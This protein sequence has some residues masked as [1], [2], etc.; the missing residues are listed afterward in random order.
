M[1]SNPLWKPPGDGIR[2]IQ[3]VTPRKKSHFATCLSDFFSCKKF[4]G[5]QQSTGAFPP[6]AAVRAGRQLVFLPMAQL[7]L[8]NV[9]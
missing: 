4:D 1:T 5:K 2:R 3:E 7:K 9:L 8:S 6:S